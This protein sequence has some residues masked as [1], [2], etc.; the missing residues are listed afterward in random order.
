MSKGTPS[1]SSAGVAGPLIL[2]LVLVAATA[3]SDAAAIHPPSDRCRSQACTETR[4][5]RDASAPDR[6]PG[7]SA[8]E[9]HGVLAVET[10]GEPPPVEN[11]AD[12]P[13][14]RDDP[15]PA[16]SRDAD[17]ASASK[18][19][20]RD[21]RLEMPELDAP[22]DATAPFRFS[23]GP[24]GASRRMTFGGDRNDIAHRPPPYF[25]G[26][27]EAS[28]ALAHFEPVAATL[29]L[30]TS[31]GYGVSKSDAGPAP[32]GETLVTE[33][34]FGGAR[35]LLFRQ[36]AGR[37]HVGVGAG[38]RATSVI[39]QPNPSYTG[40]RYLA[41][42]T[43]LRT[44]WRAIPGLLT[45]VAEAAAHP[46]FTTSNSDGAHGPGRSFGGRAG[47]DLVWRLAPAAAKPGLRRLRLV[48]AYRFQRYR[49]QF[50]RSPVGGNGGTAVDN[51]HMAALRFAFAIPTARG[52]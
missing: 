38:F 16:E 43:G 49:S 19:E 23:V 30:H 21:A 28:G 5:V 45:V 46:V 25:G 37:L 47:G 26:W 8:L 2:I 18:R 4:H 22:S 29:R 44:R 13:V 9:E 17:S 52:D 12:R 15:Q 27:L 3:P 39:L 42:E 34:M 14:R 6:P 20:E 10:P 40:H 1:G 7:R 50:P 41:A 11:P 33:L 51:Q 24:L 48:A 36:L 31:L 35:L 32:A